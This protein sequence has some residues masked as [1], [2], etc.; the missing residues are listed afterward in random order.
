MGWWF[1]MCLK[2]ALYESEQRIEQLEAQNEELK[3]II[4]RLWPAQFAPLNN[5]DKKELNALMRKHG[6]EVYP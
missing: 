4:R 5:E 6:I 2:N 1:S 3:K